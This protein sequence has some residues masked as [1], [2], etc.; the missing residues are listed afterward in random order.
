MR[1]NT[2][3]TAIKFFHINLDFQTNPFFKNLD[4]VLL[5]RKIEKFR[6]LYNID[7]HALVMMDTHFHVL[8]STQNQQ[9]NFFVDSLKKDLK[10]HTDD[11]FNCEPILND[12]Q[13]LNAYKYIYRNP[14]EA[15]LTSQVEYYEFSSLH[16]LL[17]R[18]I[19]YCQVIDYLRVIQNPMQTLKWLNQVKSNYKISQ[20]KDVRQDNSF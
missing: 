16:F 14:A 15:G 1:K 12:S 2:F 11:E 9:E 19:A 6:L 20:L 17:G 13:Y 4:W 10:I 8:I 18:S 3:K 7:I 5:Q